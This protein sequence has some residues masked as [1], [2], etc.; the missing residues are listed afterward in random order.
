M[1]GNIP[2]VK[3]VK[4]LLSEQDVLGC[5]KVKMVMDRGASS[6]DNLTPPFTEDVAAKE[7]RLSG[8]F[9]LLTTETMDAVTALELYRS[10]FLVEKAFGNLKERLSMSRSLF[11]SEQIPEGKLFVE[12][13]ALIYLSGIKNRMQDAGLFR[14]PGMTRE[15]PYKEREDKLQL[16]DD[17]G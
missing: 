13:A 5:S 15:F 10:K 8:F 9:A 12:F 1:A 4:R 16:I 14:C 6:G 17:L 3:T 7:K 11:S 2:G